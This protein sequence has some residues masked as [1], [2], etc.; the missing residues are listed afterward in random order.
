MWVIARGGA[1]GQFREGSC[2]TAQVS[3]LELE[4]A[5]RINLAFIVSA[6]RGGVSF[7][8]AQN[9]RPCHV[10]ILSKFALLIFFK[11]KKDSKLFATSD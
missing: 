3:L 5:R 7:V 11:K 9:L 10:A 1:T 8:A 4:A 6:Q 2:L